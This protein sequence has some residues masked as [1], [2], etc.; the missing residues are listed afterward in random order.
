MDD[1]RDSNPASNDELLDG[2]TSAFVEVGSSL[3]GLIRTIPRSRTYQLSS[4]TDELN[5]DDDLYVSHALT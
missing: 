1:F 3:K 2:L 4:H 5:A